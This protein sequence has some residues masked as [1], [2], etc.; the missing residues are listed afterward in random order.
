MAILYDTN[1]PEEVQV[2]EWEYSYD[3]AFYEMEEIFDRLYGSGDEL[4]GDIQ[5]YMSTD[6]LCDFL[7]WRVQLDGLSLD[8]YPNFVAY[9]KNHGIK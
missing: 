2:M 7:L 3:A 4:G 5:C 1:R 8:D 9:C 6:E